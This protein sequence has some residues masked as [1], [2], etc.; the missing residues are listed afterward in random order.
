MRRLPKGWRWPV[1]G[2][3]IAVVGSMVMPIGGMLWDYLLMALGLIVLLV[4]MA[5]REVPFPLALAQLRLGADDPRVL[6][7]RVA[8]AA[9]CVPRE[10]IGL[11]VSRSDAVLPDLVRALGPGHP[12]TLQARFL[13]LRLRGEHGTLPDRVAL[14]EE[15][16]DDMNRILGEGH[17]EALAVAG[18]SPSGSGRTA[19]PRGPGPCTRG[20]SPWAPGNWGR[21]TTSR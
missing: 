15:L 16:S 19:T 20:P 2:L 11:A 18:P 1:A 13:S 12:L 14:L 4:L 21:T 10:R 17:P 8:S 9:E 3:A 7:A 6:Q 5:H